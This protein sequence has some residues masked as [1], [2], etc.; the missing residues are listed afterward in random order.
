M[1]ELDVFKIKD[2][3]DEKEEFLVI[4]G[5]ELSEMDSGEKLLICRAGLDGVQHGGFGF[6]KR[7]MEDEMILE[8]C[9]LNSV[10]V[11]AWFKKERGLMS[12][13]TP[14]LNLKTSCYNLIFQPSNVVLQFVM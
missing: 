13:V 3:D 9:A 8:V 1:K 14:T 6:G 5:E 2:D 11:N 4:L 7:S 10:V 12:L